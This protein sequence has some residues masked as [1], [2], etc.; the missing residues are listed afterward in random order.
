[1]PDQMNEHQEDFE[2]SNKLDGVFLLSSNIIL[3]LGIFS[4]AGCWLYGLPGL[5]AGIVSLVFSNKVLRLRNGLEDNDES[6]NFRKIKNAR[7][8]AI[9]GIFLSGLYFLGLLIKILFFKAA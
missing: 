6:K 2:N 7:I 3:A 4:I 8:F 1:M 5:C 9:A